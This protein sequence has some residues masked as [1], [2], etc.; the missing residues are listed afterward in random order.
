MKSKSQDEHLRACEDR[1]ELVEVVGLL[2]RAF[3]NTSREFFERHVLQDPTLQ[4][5]D[6]RVLVTDG[7]I[8]S[9][10]QIFPRVMAIVGD[11]VPFGGIGNVATDP[12][13]RR[14]GLAA[15]VLEDAIRVM[16]EREY[17]FSM[18]T[19]TINAYYERFGYRTLI[20][21]VA[22]I[23]PISGKIEPG[24]RKF[25]KEDDFKRVKQLY[26][27]YTRGA[28]GPLIRGDIY[29]E[30][31]F[32]FCGEDPEKFLVFEQDGATRGYMRARLYKERVEILEYGAEGDIPG[33]FS[34]LLRAE[35]SMEPGY[36]IKLYLSKTEQS[37]IRLSVPHTLSDDTDLMILPLADRIRP[38]LEEH[39]TPRNAINFWL[40]DF[41]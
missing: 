37:R 25:R 21:E 6:T 5:A 11:E 39:L 19:T 15:R 31:Q 23:P 9:S 33:A 3:D 10:V 27:Q 24:I 34:A 13:E 20:R 18:L 1:D 14:K 41:F 28:I 4:L 16:K 2:D 26:R 40:S 35:A 7:A 30:G 8:I 12:T 38:T 17:P 22:T 29:W 32:A 36:P